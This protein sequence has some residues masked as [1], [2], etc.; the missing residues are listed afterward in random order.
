VTNSERNAFF[1]GTPVVEEEWTMS[2]LQ[3]F[4][5]VRWVTGRASNP[6]K[7]CAKYPS[8]EVGKKM[9]GEVHLWPLK[10]RW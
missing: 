9:E 6:Q 10:Q 8:T 1:L 2:F 5:T 4:N 3:Y 7:I